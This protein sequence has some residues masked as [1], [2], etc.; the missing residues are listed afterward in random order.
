MT[1]FL[2]ALANIPF[3]SRSPRPLRAQRDTPVL[4]LELSKRIASRLA[5][6]KWLDYSEAHDETEL[7]F[8]NLSLA[9]A[10]YLPRDTVQGKS[11]W[12]WFSHIK[13][14]LNPFKPVW[15]LDA[16]FGVLPDKSQKPSGK[17]QKIKIKIG[18]GVE[19]VDLC[20]SC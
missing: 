11:L 12:V 15:M 16:D 5:K 9:A 18:V 14:A 20:H 6:W 2:M 10:G 19:V 1:N 7:G 8:L 17:C 13:F 4:K 3:G